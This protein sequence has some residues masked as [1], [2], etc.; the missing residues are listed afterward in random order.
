LQTVQHFLPIP[1]VIAVIPKIQLHVAEAENRGRA[2]V[3][4][5]RNA[6]EHRFDGNGNLP[7]HLFGG[8]RGI[9]RDHFDERRGGVRIRLNIEAQKHIKSAR[10]PGKE[11]HDHQDA[12]TEKRGD[13]RA[14]RG[15][16]LRRGTQE[17]RSFRHD[18]ISFV[19]PG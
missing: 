12:I 11:R 7:F 10:D 15:L 6:E 5:T 3:L 19:Q 2:H 14:H 17:K 9:L 18:H 1:V 13:Q 8:P 4:Q 16:A